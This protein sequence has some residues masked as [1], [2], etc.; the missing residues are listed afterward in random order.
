VYRWL[1]GETP[2]IDR[3]AEPRRAAVELAGFVTALRGVDPTGGPPPQ[4]SNAFRGVPIGDGAPSVAQDKA[5]R[6]RIAR[7]AD[8]VDTDGLTAVWEAA[9][10]APAWDGPP[11]W[12][13][14]DLAS[15]N[16]LAIDG[17]LHAVIDFGCLG[18]G[19]PACDLMV[20][21]TFL[22]AES[23]AVFRATLGVDDASWAR[24]RGWGLA[25]SLPSPE[26]LS[27]TAD[28]ARAACARRRLDELVADV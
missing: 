16:L 7:L 18:V 19:D 13:H 24:G 6:H 17:R 21:W 22:S 3:I 2:T 28:P 10:A 15:G 20:A 26:S 14:G 5:V 27:D 11:V 4:A 12:V 1:D 9:L 8:M 25:M 23:R